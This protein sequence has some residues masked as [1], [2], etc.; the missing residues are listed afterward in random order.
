MLFQCSETTEYLTAIFFLNIHRCLYG[1][2]CATGPNKRIFITSLKMKSSKQ[3]WFY[4]LYFFCRNNAN[5]VSAKWVHRS[6][7]EYNLWS[8]ALNDQWIFKFPLSF[9]NSFFHELDWTWADVRL[10]RWAQFSNIIPCVLTIEPPLS[11]NNFIMLP[12]SPIQTFLFC[13]VFGN[14][15]ESSSHKTNLIR[16]Y[17]CKFENAARNFEWWSMPWMKESIHK[18]LVWYVVYWI[19]NAFGLTSVKP[20]IKK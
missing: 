5:A 19:Q 4:Y 1:A 10:F 12:S 13:F 8:Y 6:V 3:Q 14:L 16:I 7:G 9:F 2:L 17:I 18:C 11:F 15:F 20:F